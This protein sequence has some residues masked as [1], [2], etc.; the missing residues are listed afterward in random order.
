[1]EV[2]IHGVTLIRAYTKRS[3]T[4]QWV[5]IE[6]T[7]NK[8]SVEEITIFGEDSTPPEIRIGEAV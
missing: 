2:T 3:G 4:N 8:G 1:M 5:T 7:T 6:V